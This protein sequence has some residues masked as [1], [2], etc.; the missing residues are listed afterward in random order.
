MKTNLYYKFIY[1]F[2][3]EK[4]RKT[5][6]VAAVKNFFSSVYAVGTTC[7]DEGFI[8]YDKWKIFFFIKVYCY[9][10]VFLNTH[11][12]TFFEA[13]I[14]KELSILRF[15]HNNSAM[16]IPKFQNKAVVSYIILLKFYV[17]FH[18]SVQCS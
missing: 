8:P 9:L 12:V 13:S 2:S 4:T 6:N 18:L 1:S 15:L 10:K 11:I 5:S 14:L 7:F 17:Y 3:K 16:L